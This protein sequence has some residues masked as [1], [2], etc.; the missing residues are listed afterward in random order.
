MAFKES[1]IKKKTGKK[2]AKNGNNDN[3]DKCM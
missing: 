2:Q 3:E 1:Y